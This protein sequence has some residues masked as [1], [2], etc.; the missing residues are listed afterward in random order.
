MIPILQLKE[1]RLRV[2]KY[3]ILLKL[4]ELVALEPSFEVR[5]QNT[6]V[7]MICCLSYC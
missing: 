7:V 6:R 5:Y 2:V 3:L 1:L 4:T